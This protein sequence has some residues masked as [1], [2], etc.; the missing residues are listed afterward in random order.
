MPTLQ[1]MHNLQ[2]LEELERVTRRH[3]FSTSAA[4]IGGVALGAMLSETLVGAAR[5]AASPATPR[6]PGE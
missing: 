2:T 4:G 3:F 5:A 6:S 1:E